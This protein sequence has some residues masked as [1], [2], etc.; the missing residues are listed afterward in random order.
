MTLSLECPAGVDRPLH[1]SLEHWLSD[2]SGDQLGRGVEGGNSIV[3]FLFL[4]LDGRSLVVGGG[5][6]M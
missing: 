6:S 5:V 4:C 3:A 1:H 2:S